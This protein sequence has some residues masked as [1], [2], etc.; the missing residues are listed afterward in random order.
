MKLNEAL[1]YV[2]ASPYEVGDVVGLPKG[3]HRGKRQA[4]RT[5]GEI[6]IVKVT[7]VEVDESLT[8]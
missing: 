7:K 4:D 1:E 3:A 2:L 5:H 6:V 8:E